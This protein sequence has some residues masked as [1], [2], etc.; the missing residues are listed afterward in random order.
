MITFATQSHIFYSKY[1]YETFF[2]RIGDIG[3]CGMQSAGWAGQRGRG[4][5]SGRQFFL[6][7]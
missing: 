5:S 3:G 7:R 6:A 1:N 4:P 2:I